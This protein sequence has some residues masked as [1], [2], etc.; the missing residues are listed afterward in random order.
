MKF[1]AGPYMTSMSVGGVEYFAQDGVLDLPDDMDPVDLK[2]II[3]GHQ[4]TP[5]VEPEK[6]VEEQADDDLRQT[7]FDKAVALGLKPH[8]KAGIVKLQALIEDAAKAGA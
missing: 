8:H 7:L 6:P 1:K 4:L 5:Y 3:D 2:V